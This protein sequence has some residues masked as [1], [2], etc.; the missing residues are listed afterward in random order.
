MPVLAKKSVEMEKYKKLDPSQIKT[1]VK[2][3]VQRRRLTLHPHH[4]R[5]SD[6][7]P[8]AKEDVK[9]FSRTVVA[10]TEDINTKQGLCDF[11]YREFGDGHFNILFFS[12]KKNKFH[13]SAC[14]KAEVYISPA[15]YIDDYGKEQISMDKC[16][17]TRWVTY[18]KKG[19][20]DRMY[21]MAWWTGK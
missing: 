1:E 2:L 16:N 4:F 10:K 18:S 17:I 7:H 19:R 11:V 15:K 14:K 8:F 9:P 3:R 13:V 6:K 21:R 12:H 20:V 5:N